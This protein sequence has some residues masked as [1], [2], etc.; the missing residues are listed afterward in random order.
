[1]KEKKVKPF[2][3]IFKYLKHDKLKVFTY[4]LLVMFSYIPALL[5]SFF[6]GFAIEELIE[7]DFN[8]FLIFVSIKE[9]DYND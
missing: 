7:Q 3:I 6:W 2:K 4:C 5:T 8:K 9:V 1:M